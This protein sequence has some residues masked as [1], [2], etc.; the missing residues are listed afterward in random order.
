MP[1]D[2]SA[3]RG[4]YVEIMV[5]N[6]TVNC[7]FSRQRYMFSLT[8]EQWVHSGVHCDVNNNKYTAKERLAKTPT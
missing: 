1:P 7:N 2:F 3:A 8:T 6:V 4:E 5:N